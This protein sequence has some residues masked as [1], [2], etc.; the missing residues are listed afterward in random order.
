MRPEDDPTE[1]LRTGQFAAVQGEGPGLDHPGDGTGTVMWSRQ[2]S[3]LRAAGPTPPAPG[4]GPSLTALQKRL[5]FSLGA[6]ALVIGSGTVGFM[7]VEGW[8]WF[9]SLYMTIISISTTGYGETHPLSIPGRM[10]AMVVILSG[11]GVGSYVL[12]SLSQVLI[13]GVVEGTLQRSLLKM[14]TEKDLPRL[15][16]HVIVCGFGRF[17]QEICS[18]M[19]RNGRRCVVI[20]AA[21]D[22]VHRAEELQIPTVHGDASDEKVLRAAGIERA[23]AL[24]I[25]TASDA[26]NTY[27][28]LA[29]RELNPKVRILARATDEAAVKRLRRA[30][31]DQAI[32]P[33]H[34]GGQR[35]AATLLRPAVV[36]LLELAQVGGGD[37]L[38]EQI[39]V[40]AGAPLAGRTLRDGRIGE[41]FEV[42]VLAVRGTS[43]FLQF[44]ADPS[45]ALAVG[46][47][48]IAAGTPARLKRLETELGG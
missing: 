44:P 1:S 38:I 19:A 4:P 9:D 8:N 37:L 28:V 23:A 3:R 48:V 14:R 10:V 22:R 6:L 33:Y 30:G 16:G 24:A 20:E 34:V 21:E 31:A 25:A 17:G 11:V 39:D 47:T 15:S 7:V 42:L 45:R 36:D 35:M 2:E 46:D 32:S 43:G 5:G 26:M 27:V 41:R 29:A 40:R 13:E 12:V 18:E